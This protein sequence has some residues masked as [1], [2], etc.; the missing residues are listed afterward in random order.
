MIMQFEEDIMQ[1]EEKFGD[2]N[3]YK[4]PSKFEQLKTDIA[5]A[6]EELELLYRAYER[7]GQ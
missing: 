3:I 5:D 1:L 4:D 2:E 7:K 6:K